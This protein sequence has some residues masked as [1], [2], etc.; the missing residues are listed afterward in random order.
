M[1]ATLGDLQE[2]RGGEIT[3]LLRRCGPADAD[4]R[5]KLVS[6]LYPELKRIAEYRMKRERKDHTL[7][8]TALVNEFFLQLA[9]CQEMSWRTR[10]HFLAV[11]SRAMRRYLVDH[12]RAHS[13]KKR[14][15]ERVKIDLETLAFSRSHDPV[16]ALDFDEIL[17]R[18]EAQ[19]PRMAQVVELRCFGGLT[20]EEI[21]Q[22]I[23]V[24]ERTAKRDWQLAK[25]W[26]TGQLR[27]GRN[28]VE[29]GMGT[30]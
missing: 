28:H 16:D 22:S 13:A 24:D 30:D 1:R 18:L 3:M 25:A 14:G 8:P 7:Q 27:K 15:G 26:I 12:A 19:D 11:A 4:A 10:A 5:A 21:A 17:D 20:H 9:K 6:L 2:E 23:G 29:G